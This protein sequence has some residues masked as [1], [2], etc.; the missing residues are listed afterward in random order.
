MVRVHFSRSS[1]FPFAIGCDD[2]TFTLYERYAKSNLVMSFTF[3]QRYLSL[4][5]QFRF[6][7]RQCSQVHS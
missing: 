6:C 7:L 4:Q 5:N 2:N 1:S 3:L